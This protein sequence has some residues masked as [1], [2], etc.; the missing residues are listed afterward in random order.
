MIRLKPGSRHSVKL[1]VNEKQRIGT[2]EPR[3]LL[4]DF[5]RHE[6]KLYGT[7]VGCEHGV[8]GACTVMVDGRAVRSCMQLAVECDGAS[9]RTVEGLA[10]DDAL[11]VLQRAF[12]RHHALQC[13]FCTAGILMSATHFL[14]A[15]PDPSEDAVKEMLSGHICRCTG[16]YPIVAAILDAAGEIRSGNPPAVTSPNFKEKP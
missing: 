7:H 13:G 2:A 8:C 11:N 4:T 9:V 1:T 15:N 14:A 6:L 12:N 10:Q 3:T 5:L 16:Y